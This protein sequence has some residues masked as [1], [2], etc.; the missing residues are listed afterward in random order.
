MHRAQVIDLMDALKQSLA[1]RVGSRAET[2][3]RKAETAEPHADPT[4]PITKKPPMKAT[5]RPAD[6]EKVEK[7][8]QAGKK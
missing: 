7:K 2:P 1:K 8:A 4:R 6:Q 5:T 3:V